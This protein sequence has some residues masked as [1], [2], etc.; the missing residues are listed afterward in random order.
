MLVRGDLIARSFRS[1][2]RYSGGARDG[3]ANA[4]LNSL[5][6]CDDANSEAFPDQADQ[7]DTFEHQ[8]EKRESQRLNKC[9]HKS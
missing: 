7:S 5:A 2:R 1:R 6:V 9:V 4:T 8:V 3:E